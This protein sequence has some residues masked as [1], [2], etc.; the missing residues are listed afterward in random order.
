MSD[1]DNISPFEIDGNDSGEDDM[2]AE[3]LDDDDGQE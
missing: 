3:F 2:P 1:A